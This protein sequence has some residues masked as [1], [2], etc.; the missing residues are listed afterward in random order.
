MN[1]NY[2]IAGVVAGS[3]AIVA[4]Y[5][6]LRRATGGLKFDA[7]DSGRLKVIVEPYH[8]RYRNDPEFK[9]VYND[10]PRLVRGAVTHIDQN[11]KTSEPD[12]TVHIKFDDS[13]END[14]FILPSLGTECPPT[15]FKPGK[16]NCEYYKINIGTKALVDHYQ[17][18]TSI[19]KML[20]HEFTHVW[21]LFHV[22][23]HD[24]L[25][26]YIIEGVPIHMANQ[27]NDILSTHANSDGKSNGSHDYKP[28]EIHVDEYSR[29][30]QDFQTKGYIP[31]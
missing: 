7:G 15:E 21:M 19:N 23:D 24:S 12:V 18:R 4:G 5:L 13:F 29:I 17:N 27:A 22:K 6:M 1:R 3:L 20:I 9:R 2:V 31:I 25:P 26:D 14:P 11:T 28:G 8:G 16:G 30:I 10:F